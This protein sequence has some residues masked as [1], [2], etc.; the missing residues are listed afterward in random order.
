[1]S[2]QLRFFIFSS[3]KRK[4]VSS[5]AILCFYFP[6]NFLRIRNFFSSFLLVV[7]Y[8]LF[9]TEEKFSRHGTSIDWTFDCAIFI[10]PRIARRLCFHLV[11]LVFNAIQFAEDHT[12]KLTR[13]HRYRNRFSWNLNRNW[14]RDVRDFLFSAEF[15]SGKVTRE[16]NVGSLLGKAPSHHFQWRLSHSFTIISPGGMKNIKINEEWF[17]NW[18]LWSNS[19]LLRKRL[20]WA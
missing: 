16:K 3:G 15:S 6:F 14:T 9:L 11:F 17:F 2:L 20:E 1:M 5:I 18:E 13:V 12:N 7:L 10:P 4:I 8:F 19:K